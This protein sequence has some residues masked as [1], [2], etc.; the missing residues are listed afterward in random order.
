MSLIFGLFME[1]PSFISIIRHKFRLLG[2]Q[3]VQD[4]LL[5]SLAAGDSVVSLADLDRL[6]PGKV[7]SKTPIGPVPVCEEEALQELSYE[8]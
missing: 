3:Q 2:Q 6:V 7:R 8:R 4:C 1:G 5:E